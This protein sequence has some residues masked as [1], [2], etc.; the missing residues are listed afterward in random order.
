MR[1]WTLQIMAGTGIF[2]AIGL[3]VRRLWGPVEGTHLFSWT[4]LAGNMTIK[5]T[6]THQ[7]IN[8]RIETIESRW[9]RPAKSN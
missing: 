7:T 6:Q 3:V 4:F 2:L 9:V 5:T 1:S 8:A